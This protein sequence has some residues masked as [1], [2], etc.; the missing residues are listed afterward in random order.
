VLERTGG[1]A[2]PAVARRRALG[3]RAGL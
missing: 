1:P 3:G 2:S